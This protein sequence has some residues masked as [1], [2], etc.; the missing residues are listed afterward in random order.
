MN[1]E[2][3]EHIVKRLRLESERLGITE[4]ERITAI[5]DQALAP[6]EN[7]QAEKIEA[8]LQKIKQLLCRIPAI[9]YIGNSKAGEA[10]WWIKFR[11]RVDS[12]IAWNV[13]QELGHILNYL[14][15]EERLPTTFHPVSAPPYLNGG[16]EEYLYWVIEPTIPFLNTE[17]V[18]E[19]L[20]G[21]LP[22]DLEK[23]ES[24]I[25]E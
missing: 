5:L 1:I 4:Q 17:L 6:E 8:G 25:N 12:K 7:F 11:I 9:G 24:W 21:R 13:V 16:P 2:L 10:Y 14:S 18:Y 19:Y 20:E 3:P 23:E 15:Y 22:K